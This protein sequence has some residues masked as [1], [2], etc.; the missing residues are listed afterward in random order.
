MPAWGRLGALTWR[1]KGRALKTRPIC[2]L[3][4]ESEVTLGG[5]PRLQTSRKE[6]DAFKGRGT[7]GKT[8]LSSFVDSLPDA[9]AALNAEAF[10]Y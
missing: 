1:G 5:S 9:N 7:G 6:A 4:T 2:I 10:L 3:M 8:E